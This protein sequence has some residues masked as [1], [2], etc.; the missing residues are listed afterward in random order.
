MELNKIKWNDNDAVMIREILSGEEEYDDSS[1]D[2]D[3][4]HHLLSIRKDIDIK[5][6]VDTIFLMLMNPVQRQW[7]SGKNKNDDYSGEVTEI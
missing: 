4:D 6:V 1:D 7:L 5:N 3:A 2:D